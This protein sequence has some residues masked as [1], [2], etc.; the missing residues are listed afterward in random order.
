MKEE[1]QE[2]VY[3]RGRLEQ[4]HKDICSGESNKDRRIPSEEKPYS[5]KNLMKQR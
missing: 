4:R 1:I 2:R 5:I 3:G